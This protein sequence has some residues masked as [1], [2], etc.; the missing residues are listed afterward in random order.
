[1]LRVELERE[2]FDESGAFVKIGCLAG[3]IA[4]AKGASNLLNA[5]R[6]I[7]PLVNAAVQMGILRPLHP[8]HLSPLSKDDY[9]I[10]LVPFEELVEWGL[11][12][13]LFQFTKPPPPSSPISADSENS[14]F[15][16][17]SE[18]Q[19]VAIL[20]AIG[21]LK[22]NPL[23]LTKAPSGKSGIKSIIRAQ[24]TNS[25]KDIFSSSGVFDD[26]WQRLRNSGKI[27]DES[28]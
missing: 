25:R 4:K 15:V 13:K 8:E 6:K 23:S 5:E 1:M 18:Q 24:L 9:G 17:R 19:A 27:R 11:T 21:A 28:V 7:F 22:M 3:A 10:G 2:D 12:T 26:A 20:A 16:P 14:R